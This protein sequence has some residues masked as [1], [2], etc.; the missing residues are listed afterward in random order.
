MSETQSQKSSNLARIRDN[1]RRSRARRKEYLQE[2]ETKYRE[3]EQAGV[4]ASAE[5]QAAARRVVDEN[6]RL[7]Q[8]LRQHG[9]TDAEIGNFGGEDTSS[10]LDSMLDARR[11][12]NAVCKSENSRGGDNDRTSG[13]VSTSDS[14]RPA[15]SPLPAFASPPQQQLQPGHPQVPQLQQHHQQMYAQQHHLNPQPPYPQAAGHHGRQPTWP[16]ELY[17]HASRTA[18][19]GVDYTQYP[20]P[21]GATAT[22]LHHQQLPDPYHHHLQNT[23][24]NQQSYQMSPYP[25]GA[26]TLPQDHTLSWLQNYPTAEF[27][28]G[29]PHPHLQP[30]PSSHSGS[31]ASTPASAAISQGLRTFKPEERFGLNEGMGCRAC[32]EGGEGCQ[33]CRDVWGGRGTF[34]GDGGTGS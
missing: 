6:K 27:L 3:C 14:P 25:A 7:R 8:L 31:H 1:Q 16:P 15:P 18:Q 24:Y 4:A 5:I 11:S 9:L 29:V 21:P 28:K 17:A 19:L 33:D 12:C 34:G 13:S 26:P 20:P 32:V 2:L 10:A 23:P 30:T 22:S